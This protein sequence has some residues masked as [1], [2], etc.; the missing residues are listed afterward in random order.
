MA[1][2]VKRTGMIGL[3]ALPGPADPYGPADHVAS[4]D[5][6]SCNT[7]LTGTDANGSSHSRD[8]EPAVNFNADGKGLHA[9]GNVSY[10]SPGF[11]DAQDGYRVRV[12]GGACNVTLDTAAPSG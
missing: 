3:G 2:T 4:A 8:K 1:D 5:I 7:H 6:F 10:E 9:V 12:N 11:G